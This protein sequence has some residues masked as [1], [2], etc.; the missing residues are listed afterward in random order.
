[1]EKILLLKPL[2]LRDD[3]RGSR[4][5]VASVALSLYEKNRRIF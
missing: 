1:L 2:V 3:Y 4:E 5:K